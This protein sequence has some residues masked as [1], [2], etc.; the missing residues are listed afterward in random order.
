MEAEESCSRRAALKSALILSLGYVIIAG[1]WILA[2][3]A[4]VD[5]LFPAEQV[6]LV[7]TLKG[8]LFVA[9]S[10]LLIFLVSLK[11]NLALLR[12]RTLE[13]RAHYDPVTGVPN[14]HLFLTQLGAALK[15]AKTHQGRVAV[16]VIRLNELDKLSQAIGADISDDVAN[17]A[18]ERIRSCLRP[19]D[20]MARLGGRTFT[21]MVV[22]PFTPVQVMTLGQCILSVMAL[23]IKV[24]AVLEE[25]SVRPVAGVGIFPDNGDTAQRLLHAAEVAALKA[26]AESGNTGI[27]FYTP[28]FSE[29]AA[30]QFRLEL[31]LKQ[32]IEAGAFEVHYQPQVDLNT[33]RIIGAE[34]LIRWQDPEQ[35]DVRPEVFIPLA[36]ETGLISR[37]SSFVIRQVVAMLDYLQKKGLEPVAV[38]INISGVEIAGGRVDHLIQMAI[39]HQNIDPKLLEVEI[40]ET[41]A[42]EDPQAT[43]RAVQVLRGNGIGVALDDFGTG[44]SS[45]MHL[46]RFKLDKLKIDQAFVRDIPGN[47]NNAGICKAIIAMA[48]TLGLQVV[49]EGVETE[50]AARALQSYGCNLAQGYLFSPPVSLTEFERLLHNGLPA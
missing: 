6:R 37:I 19:D 25:I 26:G 39:E 27:E 43:G 8:W 12:S 35:G 31:R 2:S 20:R 32:A 5:A 16:I 3:D 36:E 22:E 1:L 11:F 18:V 9:V 10:G 49:A 46:Q 44:Y 30:D 21:I 23:P 14:R 45:L 7:Q 29:I 28:H 38:A 48:H 41:A 50:E 47:Q 17:T 24:N 33:R 40:T 42:M 15:D 4:A 13:R 34:A